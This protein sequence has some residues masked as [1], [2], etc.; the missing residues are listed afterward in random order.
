MKQQRKIKAMK[1][2]YNTVVIP[3]SILTF[4][5][6]PH[7]VL[8]GNC[9]CYRKIIALPSPLEDKNLCPGQKQF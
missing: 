9:W 1:K 7:S 6:V 4:K 5:L 2:N 8:S 3:Y